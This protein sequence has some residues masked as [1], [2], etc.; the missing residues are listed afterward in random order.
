MTSRERV[1]TAL[2]L[3]QPDRVP[4]IESF[5]HPSLANALLGREATQLKGGRITPDIYGTLSLDN[6]NFDFRPPLFAKMVN[7]GDLEMVQEPWLLGWEDVERLKA[8]LPDPYDDTLY[9]NAREY[10]RV[11]KKDRA[12]VAGLRLGVSPVYN[13]MGYERF[14]YALVDEPEFV[15]AAIEVYGD[16]CSK[17]ISRVNEMDF[18]IAWLSEDIAFKDGPMVTPNQYKKHIFPHMKRVAD[19]I[20]LPKIYHSDG[21]YNS[22]LDQILELK[23]S[24]IAN[25][26]PPVM[27]IFELKETHG[28][29]VCLLGNIDLHH[30]LTRGTVEETIA[31][32]KEKLEKVGKG[33][34]Y[35]IATS[36]GLVSYCK[37]E[38][39]LAMNETIQK[40]GW[41][42]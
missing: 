41:Y 28:D 6:I 13:S 5:I 22:L 23:P 10:L 7:Y 29:K 25:L 37:P 30:T 40:Y 18:D 14:V 26:E 38:N 31:E 16:W 33:G 12:A 32:V 15:E 36:N 34:G 8:W 39:V 35:I 4:W 19:Q 3:G 2:Q 9:A 11:A 21:D 17:V 42:R 27:D 1:M 20:A 24:A